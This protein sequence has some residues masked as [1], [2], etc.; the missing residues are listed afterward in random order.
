MTASVTEQVKLEA[1]S[2]RFESDALTQIV[3]NCTSAAIDRS[4]GGNRTA[5]LASNPSRPAIGHDLPLAC[6]PRPPSDLGL[7]SQH[8]IIG[9]RPDLLAHPDR[10]SHDLRLK[11]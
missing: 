4:R 1:Q 6:G 11:H 3:K 9:G 7:S 5:T 10:V 2:T 8:R